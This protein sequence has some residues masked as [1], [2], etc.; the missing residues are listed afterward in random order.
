[1]YLDYFNLKETP[2]SLTPNTDYYCDLPTH[3]ST[4][5]TILYSLNQG[6]GF[7][8][9]IGEVG[10]GKTLLC[11]KLL[12]TLDPN[13]IVSCYIPNPG[14]SPEAFRH[15]LAIE[16]G[17]DV[18][19]TMNQHELTNAINDSLLNHHECNK[20]VVLVIDEAQAMS[21]ETL[22]ALRLIT[23]LETETN[24]L[25]QIVLFGQPE[26]QYKLKKKSLRQ[27]QQRIVF[28]EI[29]KPL[30]QSDIHKYISR[31]LIAAGH[32]TGIL[33]AK[34]AIKHLFKKS[35]GIPRVLNTLCDKSLMSA[36]GNQHAMIKMKDVKNAINDSSDILETL[37]VRHHKGK[38]NA[39]RMISYFTIFSGMVWLGVYCYH[40]GM[41]V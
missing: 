18:S 3:E 19:N 32:T 26:L 5:A 20:K 41:R 34:R 25:L 1:M 7:I 11:R 38:L 2:F 22:E 39:S 24:K 30:S 8:K 13:E 16:L 31:R 36:Y 17:I 23:N 33:F 4:L 12:N 21:D 14:L 15:A 27:L 10:L 29:I 35:H 6:D 9:V 28:S 40:Y 37:D